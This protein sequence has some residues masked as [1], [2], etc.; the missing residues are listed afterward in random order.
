MRP[1]EG[2]LATDV[3]IITDPRSGMAFE[4][5]VYPGFRTVTYHVSIAWGYAAIKPEHIAVLLG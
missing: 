1:E 2:D 3:E 5:S 4:V